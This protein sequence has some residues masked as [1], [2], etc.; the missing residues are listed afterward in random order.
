M[1]QE[2]PQCP[3]SIIADT[4]FSLSTPHHQ[5]H[6]Y[7]VPG[8]LW[9]SNPFEMML[10]NCVYPMTQPVEFPQHF[11][12]YP[13]FSH[14]YTIV[15]SLHIIKASSQSRLSPPPAGVFPLLNAHSTLSLYSSLRPM[16]HGFFC[17]NLLSVFCPDCELLEFEMPA[18][19]ICISPQY[20]ACSLMQQTLDTCF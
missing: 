13:N 19:H 5:G 3:L 12:A 9:V 1:G 8:A 6:C 14:F 20:V 11:S 18:L 10:V 16:L 17:Y 4:M 7:F 2:K 15:L